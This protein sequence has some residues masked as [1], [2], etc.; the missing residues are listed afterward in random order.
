MQGPAE[1]PNSGDLNPQGLETVADFVRWA[2]SE[3]NR[4]GL[5]FGHGTD[6]AVDEALWLVLHGLSLKPPLP[7]ALFQGRLTAV[8]SERVVALVS[9]RIRTRKPAAYLIGEARFADLDFWVNEQVLVPRS[10][11]AELIRQGFEPWREGRPIESA[12]DLCTGSGCIAIACALHLGLERVHATDLSAEALEV[13]RRNV[14]RYG[15]ESILTLHQG[16][17]FADVPT[18]EEMDGGF[19]LIV[20]NPPYVDEQEMSGLPEE[21]R[22]EPALGLVAEEQGTALAARIIENAQRYLAPDGL[23]VIEVGNAA[24]ALA[25]RFEELPMDWP[26]FEHG[27]QGVCVIQAVDLGVLSAPDTGAY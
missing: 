13:A 2:A 23:L 1:P 18:G 16:D 4:A 7:D 14:A 21:F 24:E 8:E 12:L 27:G 10:P 5:Y 20:S 11:L 26:V 15:L 9:E 22:R 6:N 25:E 19:D 3:F 17:L